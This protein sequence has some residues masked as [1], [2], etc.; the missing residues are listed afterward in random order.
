M[1]Q[2]AVGDETRTSNRDRDALVALENE[3]LKMS[4][5]RQN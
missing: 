5:M 4:I 2:L 1:W 3:W